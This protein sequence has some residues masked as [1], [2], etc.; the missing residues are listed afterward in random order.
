MAQVAPGPCRGDVCDVAEGTLV[1]KE[2]G[3]GLV[4]PCKKQR[5]GAEGA[6]S[7]D[8][9]PGLCTAMRRCVLQPSVGAGMSPLCTALPLGP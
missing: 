4:S 7:R 3:W 2:L 8:H 9:G 5:P 1:R 6:R